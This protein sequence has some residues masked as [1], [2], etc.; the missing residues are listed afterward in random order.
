MTRF[1]LSLRIFIRFTADFLVAIFQI[2]L[3]IF[4][5]NKHLKPAI[6]KMDIELTNEWALWILSLIIFLIPGSLIV[7]FQLEERRIF[8]YFFHSEDPESSL[9]TLKERFERPLMYLFQEGDK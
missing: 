7:E 9:R 6:V 5:S 2:I 1:F 4:R 3:W 8:I